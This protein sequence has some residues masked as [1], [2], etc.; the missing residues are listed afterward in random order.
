MRPIK[1]GEFS[2]KRVVKVQELLKEKGYYLGIID[3]DFGNKTEKAVKDFQE[4]TFVTG[5]V[6]ATTF[7]KLSE[8]PKVQTIL[9]QKP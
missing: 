2:S 1:K 9:L 3:G 4:A 5:I 8:E 7:K 6:D